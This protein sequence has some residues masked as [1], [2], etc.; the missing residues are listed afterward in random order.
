MDG[1]NKREELQK[2]M[3]ESEEYKK[4]MEDVSRQIQLIGATQTEL[5]STITAL[6]ALKENKSGTEILVPLGSNSFIRAELKDTEKVLIGVGANISLEK[7]TDGAKG[8]LE[9]RGEE[10]NNTIVKLQTIAKE[11]NMT[12]VQ[13]NAKS[14]GLIREIQSEG[15]GGMGI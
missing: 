14:E 5:K 13:L 15:S 7:T 1:I 6:D 4:R 8:F 12:M 2:L 3:A 10:M 9:S 11:I